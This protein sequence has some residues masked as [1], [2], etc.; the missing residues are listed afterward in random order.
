MS[1]K[2]P[3]IEC[4]VLE[5]EERK[6][7]IIQKLIEELWASLKV[8]AI[9]TDVTLIHRDGRQIRIREQKDDDESFEIFAEEKKK[10]E[11]T[12]TMK[13]MDEIDHPI[14]ES[15]VETLDIY[16][17]QGFEDTYIAV[18][19]RIEYVL[20]NSE[21]WE[22]VKFA[23]DS[24]Q[25]I[26]GL[27]EGSHIPEFLEIESSDEVIIEKYSLLLWIDPC[28]LSSKGPRELIKMYNE[29]G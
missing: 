10:R 25:E 13:S 20:Q 15:F 16:R 28:E 21:S 26:S 5:I 6:E 17:N 23:F 4:K 22:D 12:W 27:S 14:W 29:K 11:S 1:V 7:A 8:D 19:R 18:K 3:E 9:L 24:Y 2:K